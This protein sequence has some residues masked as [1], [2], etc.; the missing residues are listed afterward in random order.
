M[1]LLV[2][3][4]TVSIAIEKHYCGDVLIDVSMFV[5]AEKCQMETLEVLQEKS[6]CK[7][8]IQVV[9][10]QDEL[11][12]TSSDDLDIKQQYFF[13]SYLF[14]YLNSFESLPKQTIPHQDYAPP[15]LVHDIHVLD[16]VYL[17]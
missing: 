2:L 17:I 12:V 9:K 13:A 14:S 11:S 3:F 1:A 16:E 4:S 7:D 6:C 10:G 8:E 15:N 5:E